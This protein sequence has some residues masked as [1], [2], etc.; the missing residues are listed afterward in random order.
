M[1]IR[2]TRPSNSEPMIGVHGWFGPKG[3]F[4]VP[5]HTAFELRP[6]H[7]E[8]WLFFVFRH[9]LRR[10]KGDSSARV[11]NSQSLFL[12]KVD[13]A[14][15]LKHWHLRSEMESESTETFAKDED[16][17]AEWDMAMLLASP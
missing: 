9:W 17:Q 16:V 4:F 1:Y 14:S 11:N 8:M 10:L 15:S 12:G 2:A 7:E 13:K 5:E 3:V 6:Q